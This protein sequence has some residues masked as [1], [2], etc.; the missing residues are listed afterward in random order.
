MKCNYTE[1]SKGSFGIIVKF[2]LKVRFVGSDC[3]LYCKM[4]GGPVAIFTKEGG[5]EGESG[6]HG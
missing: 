1:G 6:I 3:I 4:H 5:G 2:T